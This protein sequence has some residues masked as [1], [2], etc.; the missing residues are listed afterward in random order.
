MNKHI[1]NFFLSVLLNLFYLII[2]ANATAYDYKN[3]GNDWVGQC[4]SGLKQSPINID[5]ASAKFFQSTYFYLINS[6]QSNFNILNSTNE[7]TVLSDNLGDVFFYLPDT[8]SSPVN[9][10]SDY[11]I[12]NISIH[13]PSEHLINNKSFD[14]EIQI[15]SQ[16]KSGQLN[17]SYHMLSLL[18]TVDDTSDDTDSFFQN[19]LNNTKEALDINTLV[20]QDQ[21]NFKTF[22]YEGSLTVPPC[23]EN[24]IWFV[25]RT[26]YKISLKNLKTFREKWEYNLDFADGR[27]N[28]RNIQSLN[29]RVV[30][31][32]NGENLKKNIKLT[33]RNKI[34]R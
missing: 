30:M 20:F 11:V 18:C 17:Y 34:D 23:N 13:A 6:N 8:S 16:F 3:G 9:Q 29:S 22:V 2:K 7:F 12:K 21:T 25:Q 24:I 26:P 14:L 5:T 1:Q 28:N 15:L 4:A 19:I 33:R 32:N 27:G 31:T 10:D